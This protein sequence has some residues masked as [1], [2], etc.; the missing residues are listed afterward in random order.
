MKLERDKK[1]NAILVKD[2]DALKDYQ[3]VRKNKREKN[4]TIK[5]LVE[6]LDVLEKK[7]EELLNR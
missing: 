4:M 1:N 3:R 5:R 2:N 6:R 7:I